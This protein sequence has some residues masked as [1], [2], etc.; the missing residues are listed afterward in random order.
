MKSE[1]TQFFTFDNLNA[2]DLDWVYEKGKEAVLRDLA[3]RILLTHTDTIEK[4]E[5]LAFSGQRGLAGW[6]TKELIEITNHFRLLSSPA[7][8][9]RL[10][11]ESQDQAFLSAP[12]VREFYVLALNKIGLPMEAIQ[13]GLRITESGENSALIW[14]AMGESYSARVFFTEQ[15]IQLLTSSSFLSIQKADHALLD[16]LPHFFPEAESLL[17]LTISQVREMRRENLQMATRIF[18]RGFLDSGSSFSGLGWMLRTVDHLTDLMIERSQLQ[19]KESI[20]NDIKNVEDAFKNQALLVG[21]TLEL[22]G[23]MEALDYWTRAG[24]A[25]LMVMR[26]RPCL[27]FALSCR[28]CLPPPMPSLS[29]PLP[30]QN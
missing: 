6:S 26:E 5:G 25:L 23:G 4:L 13:E 22:Q 14:A 10:Y 18:S 30:Y 29:L 21:V 11:R 1:Q 8:E 17:G 28:A 3:F 16:Q 24:M 20:D 2:V 7:N 12:R 9:I 15:L 19:E 27:K